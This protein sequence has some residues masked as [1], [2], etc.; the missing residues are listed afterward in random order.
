[1]RVPRVG[2]G[3][4]PQSTSRGQRRE[5]GTEVRWQGGHVV[6]T[7]MVL[8]HE[9]EHAL[10]AHTRGHGGS[11]AAKVTRLGR[12]RREESPTSSSN[13]SASVDAIGRAT[14]TAALFDATLDAIVLMDGS[15]VITAWNRQAESLFGWAA[16]DVVGCRLSEVIIPERLREAHEEGLRRYALSGH[17]PLID[18]HS[19][20]PAMHRDG[21]E[22]DAEVTIRKSVG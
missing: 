1:M 15:G 6:R 14:V 17:G 11:M 7:V 20:V 8:T 19:E 16:G 18:R 3:P 5:A 22:F 4:P 10:L 2:R 13:E 21:H 9:V 12:R